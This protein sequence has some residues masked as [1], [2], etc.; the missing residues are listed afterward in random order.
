M[1][2]WNFLSTH[3][4]GCLQARC[5]PQRCASLQV[6]CTAAACGT[7]ISSGGS[8]SK[9]KLRQTRR[10]LAITQATAEAT[11]ETATEDLGELSREMFRR[12]NAAAATSQGG[13]PLKCASSNSPLLT[14]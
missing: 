3:C 8:S 12:M 7:H 1:K 14:L 2:D 11:S 9:L 13:S 6:V 4:L 10:S 5:E